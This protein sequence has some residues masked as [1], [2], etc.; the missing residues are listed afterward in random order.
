M[1]PSELPFDE[2]W[3]HDFEFVPQPGERPDVVCL[4]AHELR[5]GQTLRLWRDELGEQPPYRTDSG[6][7]FV[8]FVCT[9]PSVRATCPLAGRCQHASSIS[10]LRFEIWPTVDRRQKGKD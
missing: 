9:R 7:L 5:S 2:I 6:V 4:V 10:A 8:S 1:T 3:L